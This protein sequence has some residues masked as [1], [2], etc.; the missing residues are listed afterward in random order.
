MVTTNAGEGVEN[1]DH[2]SF[3]GGDVKCFIGS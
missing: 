2:P 1:L 3:A